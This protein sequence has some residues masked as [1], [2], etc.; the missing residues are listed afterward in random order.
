MSICGIDVVWLGL[1]HTYLLSTKTNQHILKLSVTEGYYLVI[2][3][4][5]K[6]WYGPNDY[7]DCNQSTEKGK[8]WTGTSARKNK[9]LLRTFTKDTEEKNT[10]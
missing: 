7:N 6:R 9:G 5:I 4:I 3:Y 1:T 2:M 10:F 8:V